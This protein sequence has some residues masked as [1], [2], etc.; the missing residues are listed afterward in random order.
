MVDISTRLLRSFLVLADELNF[1]QASRRLMLAQQT[2]SSQISQ[3][4]KA[5]GVPLLVRTTRS[6]SLTP[7]GERLRVDGRAWLEAFD[8]LI[9]SIGAAAEAQ[10]PVIRLGV[11]P[12]GA[13]G[14]VSRLLA[15]AEQAGFEIDLRGYTPA[16]PSCGLAQGETDVAI[17]FSPISSEVDKI[18]LAAEP[19]L[20]AIPVDH[21]W[22]GRKSIPLEEVLSVPLLS[23]TSP[24]PAWRS[25][26][27]LDHLRPEGVTGEVSFAA[28]SLESVMS[29]VAAGRGIL[30]VVASIETDL[31]RPGIVYAP[32]DGAPPTALIAAVRRGER[33]PSVIRFTELVRK[34]ASEE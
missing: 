16:D 25:Y 27:R 19:I 29:M 24:D 23:G 11:L 12:G 20:L 33:R 9:D 13:R 21:E 8:E 31:P 3:L 15:S 18:P 30:P 10:R 2:L 17:T 5:I 22:A 7:A 34:L 26:W 14:L 28:H 4:E 6:V 1:T 32:I